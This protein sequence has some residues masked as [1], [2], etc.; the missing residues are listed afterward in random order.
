[1]KKDLNFIIDKIKDF[2]LIAI[3]LAYMAFGGFVIK[4]KWFLTV[5]DDAIIAYSLGTLLIF[6]GAFRVYRGIKLMKKRVI[7]KKVT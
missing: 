2:L 5:I 3:G 6:Y 1:M 4:E 7:L